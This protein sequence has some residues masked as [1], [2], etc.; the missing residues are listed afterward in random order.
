[1]SQ[2]A[3][4]LI[5]TVGMKAATIQEARRRLR[6]FTPRERGGAMDWTDN[7]IRSAFYLEMTNE[8]KCQAH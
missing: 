7:N 2:W 1:M 8:E 4:P 3:H 6:K 5:L